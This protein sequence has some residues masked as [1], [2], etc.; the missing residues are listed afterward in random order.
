MDSTCTRPRHVG[1]FVCIARDSAHDVMYIIPWLADL[2]VMYTGDAWMRLRPSPH[3]ARASNSSMKGR[4]DF[5][6]LISQHHNM[7]VLPRLV[8]VPHTN[9]RPAQRP[10]VFLCRRLESFCCCLAHDERSSSD[11]TCL[12]VGISFASGSRAVRS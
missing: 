7:K 5:V 12:S 8:P 11:H 2:H 1:Y 6:C 4:T 9:G 10:G 3:R